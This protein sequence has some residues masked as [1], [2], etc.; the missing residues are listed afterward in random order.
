MK[1]F[2]KKN[3][4]GIALFYSWKLSFS[5]KY[6]VAYI[7]GEWIN[8][9]AVLNAVIKVGLKKIYIG[10]RCSVK[11]CNMLMVLWFFFSVEPLSCLTSMFDKYYLVVT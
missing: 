11:I 7:H 1:N 9:Q 6:S 8:M 3:E 4:L 2:E 10:K 5:V